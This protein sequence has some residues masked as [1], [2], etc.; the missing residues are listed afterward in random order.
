MKVH[1]NVDFY[2]ITRNQRKAVQKISEKRKKQP[3]ENQKNT[4]Y[5]NISFMGTLF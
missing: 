4:E 1:Q 3:T 2:T 5:R